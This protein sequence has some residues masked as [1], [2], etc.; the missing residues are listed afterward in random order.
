[1]YVSTET[2][3]IEIGVKST[4]NPKLSSPLGTVRRCGGVDAPV[5]DM[6][7]LMLVRHRSFTDNFYPGTFAKEKLKK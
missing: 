6:Y 1:M 7:V 4:D 2:S 5:D 3:I